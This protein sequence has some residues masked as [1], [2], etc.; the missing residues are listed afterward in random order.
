MRFPIV[1]LLLIWAWHF[2]PPSL[3]AVDRIVF[4][5]DKTSPEQRLFGKVIVTAADGGILL[6]TADSAL[7]TITPEQLVD[8]Q[9][10]DEQ[11]KPLATAELSKQVM[12]ELP[13]LELH[14]TK[15]YLILHGTSKAYAQWVGALYERLYAAFDNFWTRKGFKLHEPETPLVVLVFADQASYAKYAQAE[16]GENTKNVI[17]YYSLK[18][19]RVTMYDLTGV[20]TLR[21]PND[22]RGNTQQINTMLGKPEATAMVA[23]I[24]HEATH[25]IAFNDGLQTRFADIPYWLSEGMAVY[26]ETPDLSNPSGW[27]AIGKVNPLRLP[28]FQE[29]LATRGES[30]LESLL[31]NDKRFRDPQQAINAYAEAWALNYFLIK[32]HGDAYSKYLQMLA[33][34]KPLVWD[35]PVVRLKEFHAA[36]GPDLKKIDLEFVKQMSKVK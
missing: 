2:S 18:S 5:A 15:H 17:A 24:I 8:H 30:S 27:N 23:T 19:N 26:F 11:F 9:Q 28:T 12:A 1:L 20:E 16:L 31:V 32:Q 35:D 33:Q 22:R 34:K 29:S 21:G 25:Q 3:C 36:F 13:G 4:R 7:W 10:L 14:A 6:Q